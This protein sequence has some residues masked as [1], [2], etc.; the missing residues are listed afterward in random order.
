MPAD[1]YTALMN[2]AKSGL[3]PSDESVFGTAAMTFL[4]LA[5]PASLKNFAECGGGTVQR[6]CKLAC[7]C[8]RYEDFLQS[9]ATKTCTRSR[10]KRAVLF[11]MTGVTFSDLDSMPAYT[12]VLGATQAGRKYLSSLRKAETA[13]PFLTKPADAKLLGPAAV[14]QVQLGQAADA[15]FTLSLPAPLPKDAFLRARPVLI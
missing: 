14:R 11:A 2:A 9:C 7:A 8:S 6:L 4:R 5:D 10:A 3:C 1:A 15:L 12:Q 13:I